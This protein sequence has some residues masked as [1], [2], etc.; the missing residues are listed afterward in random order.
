MGKEKKRV[1]LLAGPGGDFG[2]HGRKRAR[3]RGRRPSRP[4]S[5]GDGGGRRPGAGPHVSEGRGLT[6]W[7]SDGGGEFDQSS[8]AGEIPRWF[9]VVGPVLWQGSGGEA[10]AGVGDHRGGV[11][12]TGGDLVWPAHGA[13]VGARGGEVAGEAAERNR[14]WGELPC[15]RECV[16]ELKHQ[17]NSTESY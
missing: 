9:S 5:E 2:P 7:S 1:F 13:V 6:A 4:I 3:E 16:A 14:R 17:I 11:N 12:L 8:T 15:D 10:W